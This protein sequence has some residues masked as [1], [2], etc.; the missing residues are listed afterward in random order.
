S[1][2]AA[3]KPMVGP[4]TAVIPLQNGVDA[5]ERLMPILGAQAP[6]CGGAQSSASIGAPGVSKQVGTFMRMIFGELDGKPSKRAEELPALCLKAGFDATLSDQIL[7][8]LWMKFVLLAA[9]AGILALALSPIG[10]VLV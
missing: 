1:A 2:G 3:I 6:T 7:T 10:R 9:N 5:H 8:E 4:D